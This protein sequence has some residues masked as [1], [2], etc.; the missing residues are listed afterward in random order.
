MLDYLA[1]GLDPERSVLFLQ[2]RVPQ[3]AELRC[4]SA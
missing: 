3:H 1:A 2:S 4:S